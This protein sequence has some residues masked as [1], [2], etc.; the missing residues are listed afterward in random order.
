VLFFS[1]ILPHFSH[2]LGKISIIPPFLQYHFAYSLL[3]LSPKTGNEQPNAKWRSR[4]AHVQL[5]CS[6]CLSLALEPDLRD[7]KEP[8]LAEVAPKSG[9]NWPLSLNLCRSG[10]QHCSILRHFAALRNTPNSNLAPNWD[11]LHFFSLFSRS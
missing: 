4:T 1:L 8:I 2:F 10:L 7:H 5:V 11:H 6:S 9:P 3:F